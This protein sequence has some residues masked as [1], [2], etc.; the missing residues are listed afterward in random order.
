MVFLA[1][2]G[3]FIFFVLPFWVIMFLLYDVY[4]IDIDP[5]IIG[6]IIIIFEFAVYCEILFQ[7]GIFNE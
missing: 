2:I 1:I 3:T 6:P 7:M 5:Y 4:K